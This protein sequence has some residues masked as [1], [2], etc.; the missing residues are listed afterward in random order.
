M[1]YEKWRVQVLNALNTP[2]RLNVVVRHS[3]QKNC[4]STSLYTLLTMRLVVDGVLSS[5]LQLTSTALTV[6][7]LQSHC[8]SCST[9]GQ[10]PLVVVSHEMP[11]ELF[12]A[13]PFWCVVCG[14]HPGCWSGCT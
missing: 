8:C 9:W 13:H 2:S 1:L 14:S 12:P 5:A 11:G 6:V 3:T 10:L 4:C 7:V